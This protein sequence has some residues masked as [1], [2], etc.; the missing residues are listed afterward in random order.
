MD[1]RPKSDIFFSNLK[2]YGAESRRAFAGLI[3]VGHNP[4]QAG[5]QAI[6][7]DSRAKSGALPTLYA[8]TRGYLP[9][10]AIWVCVINA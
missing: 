8:Q 7:I 4:K 5:L 6:L 10:R 9:K 1:E 3:C 2:V